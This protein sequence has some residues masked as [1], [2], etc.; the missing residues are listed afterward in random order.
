MLKKAHIKVGIL[1][2]GMA[3]IHVHLIFVSKMKYNRS[4]LEESL[5]MDCLVSFLGQCSIATG[6]CVQ[7]FKHGGS[8]PLK[9]LLGVEIVGSNVHEYLYYQLPPS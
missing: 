2:L 6:R 9:A 8:V 4:N 3:G 5:C 7:V 1:K